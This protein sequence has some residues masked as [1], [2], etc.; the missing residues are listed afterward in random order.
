MEKPCHIMWDRAI[1]RDRSAKHLSL[2]MTHNLR[3]FRAD[4]LTLACTRGSRLW[5]FVA[6]QMVTEYIILLPR[7]QEIVLY[8][9]LIWRDHQLWPIQVYTPTRPLLQAMRA[10]NLYQS[11]DT[12]LYLIVLCICSLIVVITE[13]DTRKAKNQKMASRTSTRLPERKATHTAPLHLP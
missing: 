12:S 9:V 5:Y 6:E 8:F 10:W 11:E 2:I 3:Q 7:P 4:K 13:A 1:A